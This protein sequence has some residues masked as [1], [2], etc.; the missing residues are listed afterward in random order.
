MSN[1]FPS[2]HCE[3]SSDRCVEAD[4]HPH[5]DA[6]RCGPGSIADH[7]E[8]KDCNALEVCVGP[9]DDAKG[10]FYC[11]LVSDAT[12]PDSKNHAYQNPGD[13]TDFDDGTMVYKITAANGDVTYSATPPADGAIEAACKA[14]KNNEYCEPDS[15]L[16]TWI[17]AGSVAGVLIIAFVAYYAISKKHKKIGSVKTSNGGGAKNSQVYKP[18]V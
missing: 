3:L 13:G 12:A 5:P 1:A 17:I 10:L 11:N 4:F 7:P 15:S 14:W 2:K 8:L 18:L 9:S 16:W 6:R